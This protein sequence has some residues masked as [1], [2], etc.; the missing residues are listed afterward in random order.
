MLRLTPM[1]VVLNLLGVNNVVGSLERFKCLEKAGKERVEH[2][3]SLA[4]WGQIGKVE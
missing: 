1:A 3:Y 2:I 4:I